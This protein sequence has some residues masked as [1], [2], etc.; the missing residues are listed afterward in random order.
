MNALYVGD[1][2]IF[3]PICDIVAPYK[4]LDSFFYFVLLLETCQKL[5]GSLNF[6][7]C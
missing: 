4:R 3:V 1:W 2:D 6:E 7:L 5:S